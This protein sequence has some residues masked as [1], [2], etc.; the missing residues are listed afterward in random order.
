MKHDFSLERQ[1]IIGNTQYIEEIKTDLTTL[2]ITFTDFKKSNKTY[3]KVVGFDNLSF[4]H[5]SPVD[6]LTDISEST[7]QNLI[8]FSFDKN[9]S[10]F[11]YCLKTDDYED[12]I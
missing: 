10:R 7:V 9:E 5:V 8:G 4:V 2:H 12:Y 11:T 3:L 1:I 6:L